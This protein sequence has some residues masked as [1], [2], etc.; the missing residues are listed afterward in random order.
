MGI[1]AK[2]TSLASQ[3]SPSWTHNVKNYNI[4]N[5]DKEKNTES[6]NKTKKN[7]KSLEK[8]REINKL[9]KR[10]R[11]V[12]NHEMAHKSAGGQYTGAI[13]YTYTN[14]PDNKRYA[15]GGSVDIDT[16]PIPNDPNKTIQKS[17]IVKRAALAPAKPSAADLK[18]AGK[19]TRMKIKAQ[20]ELRK[21][22][23]QQNKTNLNKKETSIYNK[24]NNNTIN[25]NSTFKLTA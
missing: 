21:N 2:S 11:E 8:D 14:G 19:A 7:E 10:D 6:S 16:S 9:K 4:E 23:N 18:I 17:E 20:M 5:I 13:S 22:E 15:V 12:K 1:I 24:N 3:P 25:S